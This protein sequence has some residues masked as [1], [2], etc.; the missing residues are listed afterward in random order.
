MKRVE[1]PNLYYVNGF[2][3]NLPSYEKVTHENNI[4]SVRN[5]SKIYDRQN[6]LIAIACK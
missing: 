5:T 4:I 2:D 6:N 1:I 3:Q